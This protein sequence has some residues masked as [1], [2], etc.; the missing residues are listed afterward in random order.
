MAFHVGFPSLLVFLSV[1]H[2]FLLVFCDSH[3]P[4]PFPCQNLTLEYPFT[5]FGGHPE[6]GLIEIDCD[7]SPT[8]K[9]LKFGN[10]WTQ[11]DVTNL[12]IKSHKLTVR[13]TIL[14]QD[15]N[16]HTCPS[17]SSTAA[18]SKFPPISF[19]SSPN[20][21]LFKCDKSLPDSRRVEEFF[22]GYEHYSDC[23]N[24]ILYYRNPADGNL[25]R[26]TDLPFGCLSIQL[27]MIADGNWSDDLFELLT[28]DYTI[29][30]H[31]DQPTKGQ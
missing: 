11:Y 9:I 29:E 23:D 21:T 15:L 31:V 25:T 26:E 16:A 5:E 2:L 10:E 28:Y 22:K 20:L 6:C 19:T 27:P 4:K 1:F 18:L 24:F 8:P 12:D 17:T 7:S 30:W 14:K 13:D 3:C